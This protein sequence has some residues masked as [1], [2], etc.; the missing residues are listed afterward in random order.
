MKVD[1]EIIPVENFEVKI[2]G[3][4]IGS[5][6]NKGEWEGFIKL[7]NKDGVI[8]ASDERHFVDEMFDGIIKTEKKSNFSIIKMTPSLIPIKEKE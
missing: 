3:K 6:E 8:I 7:E 5:F 2:N 1:I 4:S